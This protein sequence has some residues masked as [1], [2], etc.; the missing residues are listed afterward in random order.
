[1]FYGKPL[2]TI[3]LEFESCAYSLFV[4]GG[5][6]GMNNQPMAANE[7][8][9]INHWLRHGENLVE[10]RV[11]K[12][13][14][15]E[16]WAKTK[17]TYTLRVEQAGA[18]DDKTTDLART[19]WR[20]GSGPGTAAG[21]SPAGQFDSARALSPSKSGDVVVGEPVLTE[22]TAPETVSI[23]R[24]IRLPMPFR[25]WTFLRSDPMPEVDKMTDA[26][27]EAL[28]RD[29]LEAYQPLWKAIK[30]G[31]LASVMPVFE[32][33]SQDGRRS[34][35]QDRRVNSVTHEADAAGS[36]GRSRVHSPAGASPRRPAIHACTG[37]REQPRHHRQERQG[38]PRSPLLGQEG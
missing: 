32:E 21:S 11:L 15:P 5:L 14:T 3:K 18:S 26:E 25:E 23:K 22:V 35:I 37:V 13:P 36:P 17:A 34:S 7:I 4:N 12:P 30:S 16:E 33:R 28:Y 31:N 10:L 24:R 9:P 1:M 29:L 27:A 19:V 20:G 8:H 6:V 2:I 38:K